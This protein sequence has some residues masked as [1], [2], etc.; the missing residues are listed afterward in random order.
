MFKIFINE[1][2]EMKIFDTFSKFII[3]FL[4]YFINPNFFI[5]K[6][7]KL[8]LLLFFTFAFLQ[9]FSQEETKLLRFPHIMGEKVVFTY[10]GDIY[11]VGVN[12]G[13]AKQLTS[14]NGF[15]MFAK[16]SPD[17]KQIAFSAQYDGNTEVYV[18]PVEGGVPK[19]LTY[20]ATLSRDDVAD[21]MGPNNIVM[22]WSPDSKNI[23]F[24]SRRY[25]YNSFRGQ[26]FSVSAT[27]GMAKE[28]PIKDGGFCSFS[29]DGKFLTFNKIFREFRTWKYYTGGMA[30]DIWVYDFESKKAIKVFE[31]DAQDIFPMWS[32]DKIFFVSDRDKTMNLFSYN[33]KTDEVEKESNYK[34][35]DIKFPSIGGDKIIYENAGCLYFFDIK[36]DATIKLKITI[37]SDFPNARNR[38]VEVSKKIRYTVISPDGK[39]VAVGARGDV[40]TVPTKHG[41]TRNI[42]K[43][44]GVHE[45]NIQWSPDGKN[46]AYISDKSGE[47]E[48]YIQKQ[49]G[50]EE[51]IKITKNA[52]TYKFN[53]KW[54]P[55]SKK[56]LWCDKMLRLRYVNIETKK[57]IEVDK[58]NY[59]EIRNFAWSPSS[60]WITYAAENYGKKNQIYLYNLET[61]QKHEVTDGWYAS[62]EPSFSNDGKYLLFVSDRDY[63][64]TYSD[65]EWNHAY[66]NMGKIYLI[67]LLKDTPSPF[68]P[69]NDEVNVTIDTSKTFNKK[70]DID[71]IKN[72]IVSLPVNPGYYWNICAVD[73]KIYY[74]H[75]TNGAGNVT[76]YYYDLLENKKT[77]FGKNLRFSISSNTKKMLVRKGSK[78]YVVELPNSE[79]SLK[80]AIDFSG[81]K[82]FV[83]YQQEWK[84]IYD[85]TWRQMRDFFY[86]PNMHG[87]NWDSIHAKYAVLLPYVKH[88]NDLTYLMGEM[89][90]ELNI[91]HAYV[92]GGERP[93]IEK[94]NMG[95][96]GA[97]FSKDKKSGF[98]KIDNIL[99]GANWSKDLRS[100]LTEI[101][102]N[103]SVNDYIIAINGINTNEVANIY[104]L[105]IGTAGQQVELTVN[106]KASKT[107]GRK[108]I[109]IP[110]KEE[111]SLYYFNWVE[112]NLKKVNEAT[113]G[114]IGYLHIP[115]MGVDGLNQFA[116]YYYPQVSK[117]GL[118]I[119]DR[120][121]GG[122]NVS[123]MII[124]R[125]KRE[126]TLQRM[127]R[128]VKKRGPTPTNTVVGPKVLLINEYSASDGDLFPYKFKQLE[129]GT[130]IG[131]RTWGGVT[132]IRG[133]LP[134]VDGGTLHKPEFGTYAKDGSKWIIEGYGVDPH[135]EIDNNPAEVFQGKDAQLEKAIE[136]VL[137]QIKNYPD[138]IKEHPDF[139]I[140]N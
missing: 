135:I 71:G 44:S 53:F 86:D 80:K 11:S 8:L 47:F 4:H 48:I 130:L 5:M 101:G 131:K 107:G 45:R 55:D 91:G 39:R 66:K 87:V 89:I 95:L 90:A 108:I 72:R 132:G 139:P 61:K 19:R 49:D 133:S 111:A 33:T 83:N 88:R 110:L 92:G 35:Y 42:T 9:V 37:N 125:L 50:S 121:N 24:R 119:D 93:K 69:K 81:L 98:F 59:W 46:L 38:M 103:V 76:N 26:L 56:I 97:T 14:H 127:L 84:Q 120:G 36:N 6:R 138:Q 77:Q 78:Y 41:V 30:A 102:V 7:F 73:N 20:T 82:V 67:T 23:I 123:P 65:S 18:M 29:P 115:D 79:V 104:E 100:P 117:K 12:G 118:I 136:I 64:P 31:N 106:S 15:E 114:Q 27:G 134:F 13:E 109:V 1:I 34:N 16:I 40:F 32:G 51:A 28:G 60:N 52:D 128:N 129:L 25:S 126:L 17:G 122:G 54:S 43:T 112:A 57:V 2:H 116:R 85:E 96:L 3:S 124:E 21:R 62:Y 99:E 74:N 22:A 113:G 70:I 63:N 105:L 10:A 68:A 58:A 137:E 140:K 94:I 75:T